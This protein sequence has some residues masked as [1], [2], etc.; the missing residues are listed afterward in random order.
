MKKEL[1]GPVPIAFLFT[2]CGLPAFFV[3]VLSRASLFC[4]ICLGIGLYLLYSYRRDIRGIHFLHTFYIISALIAIEGIRELFIGNTNKWYPPGEPFQIG[5][6]PL[7]IG[8]FLLII[9]FLTHFVIKKLKSNHPAQPTSP[10][11]EADK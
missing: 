2:L 8:A 7:G 10:R 4:A 6:I 9:S 1:I 3:P 11:S 5:F